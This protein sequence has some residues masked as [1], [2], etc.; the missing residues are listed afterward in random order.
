MKAYLTLGASLLA[1]A[2]L[3]EVA[4][5]PGIVLGGAAVLA[6]QLLQGLGRRLWSAPAPADGS[7]RVAIASSQ[8]I[9]GSIVPSGLPARIG[10]KRSIAKTITFRIIVTTLDFSTNYVMI[11][12]LVTAAGLSAFTLVVAPLFY[13]GHEAAW[14][15]FG[16]VGD[17][18]RVPKLLPARIETADPDAGTLTISRALAKTITFRTIATITDFAANYVGVRDIATATVLTAFGFVIGPFVY[19]GHERLWD[20]LAPEAGAAR[21]PVA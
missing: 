6:P 4:L 15:Y 16:P 8:V 12:E 21:L 10:I 13:L 9:P 2:A 18:V 7:R 11:G 1:G 3:F 19:F 20:R 5:I 17:N 14:N